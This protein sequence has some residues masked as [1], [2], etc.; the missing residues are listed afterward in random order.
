MGGRST[1]GECHVSVHRGQ[2]TCSLAR[3]RRN[4]GM[5]KS[6]VHD[7]RLQD[8]KE[9]HEKREIRNC[10]RA[11]ECSRIESHMGEV[12]DEVKMKCG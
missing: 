9:R 3:M 6:R 11:L 7:K 10:S 8:G 1:S 2:A 5:C 4:L 12:E